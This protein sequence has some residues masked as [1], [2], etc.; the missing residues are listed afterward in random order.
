MVKD[1]NEMPMPDMRVMNMMMPI[2]TGYI[3]LVV[4]QGVGLYW[5]TSNI[6]GVIQQ[7]ILKKKLPNAKKDV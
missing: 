5:V 1:D 7:V 2:M 3:A 4:P 6:I